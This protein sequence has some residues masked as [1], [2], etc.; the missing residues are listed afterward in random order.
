VLGNH[1]KQLD[2]CPGCG[3]ILD[4][5]MA[6][7]SKPSRHCYVFKASWRGT[8]LRLRVE[9]NDPETAQKKAEHEVRKMEGAACCLSVDLVEQIY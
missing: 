8:A 1:R 3:S 9:A 7:N 4:T 2:F 6:T 5:Q